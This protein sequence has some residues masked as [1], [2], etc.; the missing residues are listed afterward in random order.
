VPHRCHGHQCGAYNMCTY[1]IVLEFEKNCRPLSNYIENK[2][3]CLCVCVSVID[4]VRYK[5]SRSTLKYI[6]PESNIVFF[7]R[8]EVVQCRHVVHLSTRIICTEIKFKYYIAS[9]R[10]TLYTMARRD[11]RQTPTKTSAT[12]ALFYF[13]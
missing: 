12:N 7:N 10:S 11:S 5:K 13:S 1:A 2:Y 6:L 4:R 3:Y 9:F 8:S